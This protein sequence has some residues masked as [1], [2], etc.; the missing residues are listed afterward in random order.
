MKKYLFVSHGSTLN[1]AELCLL[2]SVIA[3]K[4]IECCEVIVIIPN[5]KDTILENLLLKNNA[6]VISGVDNPYWVCR[7]FRMGS[8]IRKTFKTLIKILILLYHYKPDYIIVNSI[9]TN[10]AFAIA[11][12]LLG[13]KTIWYI[14]ELGD[15]DHG[16][17]Y[18]L[19][20]SNTFRIVR[21]L[22]SRQVFNS[23]YTAHHFGVTRNIFM[24]K[25]PVIVNIPPTTSFAPLHNV[26][27]TNIWHI[28]LI[29]RTVEGKGQS[30]IIEAANILRCKYHIKNFKISIVGAVDCEYLRSLRAL[31]QKY[32][33]SDLIKFIPFGEHVSQFL[34]DADVGVTTSYHES[35]GRITVE[36]LKSGLV[37]VGASS[38]GTKEI[39]DE[40]ETAY[41]YQPDDFEDLAGRL[42]FIIN[43]DMR[44]LV[45]QCKINAL[46]ATELYSLENHYQSLKEA[47]G[48]D[49][50][51]GGSRAQL[52]KLNTN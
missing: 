35:F 26:K 9:V 48:N 15:L 30:Q 50:L 23:L 2:E 1:G 20:K 22:S 33:L 11:S 29:G 19:G 44:K 5:Q 18:L 41:Q 52:Y 25:N 8:F 47:L 46:K 39:L 38:G 21:L 32:N 4:K 34:G 17:R 49:V 51:P 40:F 6:V 28:V 7:E 16:W 27:R 12:R 42:H 10:P 3:F 37:T 45:L 43:S 24:A 14:H 31:A 36:Y 13:L